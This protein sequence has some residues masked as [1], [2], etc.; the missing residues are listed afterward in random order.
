MLDP[1]SWRLS[2]LQKAFHMYEYQETLDQFFRWVDLCDEFQDL[3]LEKITATFE[4]LHAS[5]AQPLGDF[6][7]FVANL[8]TEA[9]L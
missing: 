6:G 2:L 9:F 3:P 8:D 7:E 4:A 5:T 1:F